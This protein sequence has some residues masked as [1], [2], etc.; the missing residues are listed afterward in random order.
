[1]RICSSCGKEK[2]TASQMKTCKKCRHRKR[3]QKQFAR[4]LKS[5]L[6]Y[7][8]QVFAWGNDQSDLFQ[9]TKFCSENTNNNDG[10]DNNRDDAVI[11]NH[12]YAEDDGSLMLE[13]GMGTTLDSQLTI[14][15][16]TS[17]NESDIQHE[18]TNTNV[19]ASEDIEEDNYINFI[20]PESPRAD[21]NSLEVVHETDIEVEEMEE[22]MQEYEE[23]QDHDLIDEELL[24]GGNP[25][26]VIEELSNRA[27]LPESPISGTSAEFLNPEDEEKAIEELLDFNGYRFDNWA[28]I[29]VKKGNGAILDIHK[30]NEWFKRMTSTSKLLKD[31]STKARILKI[32]PDENYIGVRSGFLASAIEHATLYTLKHCPLCSSLSKRLHHVAHYK[33]FTKELCNNRGPFQIIQGH[34]VS[35]SYIKVINSHEFPE[36]S[37]PIVTKLNKPQ[38]TR[39]LT[40]YVLSGNKYLE[41]INFKENVLDKYGKNFSLLLFQLP[42]ESEA[43]HDLRQA[44]VDKMEK[45][46]EL[47]R[48]DHQ[49]GHSLFK[50]FRNVQPRTVTMYTNIVFKILYTMIKLQELG[51]FQLDGID[52]DIETID[53]IDVIS[54]YVDNHLMLKKINPVGFTFVSSPFIVALWINHL[55]PVTCSLRDESGI[56]HLFDAVQFFMKLELINYCH[57]NRHNLEKGYKEYFKA[58]EDYTTIYKVLKIMKSKLFEFRTIVS[59]YY[60]VYFTRKYFTKLYRDTEINLSDIPVFVTYLISRFC[61]TL[62]PILSP[63]F[64]LLDFIDENYNQDFYSAT[65][66]FMPVYAYRTRLPFLKF[67]SPEDLRRALC[68]NFFK[69]NKIIILLMYFTGGLPFRMTEVLGLQFNDVKRNIFFRGGKM[70]CTYTYNKTDNVSNNTKLISR[71]YPVIVSKVVFFYINYARYYELRLMEQLKQADSNK[72]KWEKLQERCTRYLFVD[73]SGI[74]QQEDMYALFMHMSTKFIKKRLGIRDWRQIMVQFVKKKCF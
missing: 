57:T 7:L 31:D 14:D 16:E 47:A 27:R 1:M 11:R 22:K 59:N 73:I 50:K 38:L 43:I 15:A 52:D 12:L 28:K 46:S 42:E 33:P 56:Q 37:S 4:E 48:K 62:A 39:E 2:K 64:R 9:N 49:V 63:G 24:P 44:L 26:I 13:K 71:G 41:D 8:N 66:C 32:I 72:E 29:V 60:D 68:F 20:E 21:L 67:D 19:I 54:N 51:Y 36:I 58:T 6:M 5:H 55:E 65:S 3:K 45:I 35:L 70:L 69:L 40:E 18:N 61:D 23:L 53:S 74:V 25:D 10:R 17:D 34:K 30:T